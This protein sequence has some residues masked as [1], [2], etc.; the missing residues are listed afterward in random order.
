MHAT[1]TICTWLDRTFAFLCSFK[2]GNAH[3][4]IAISWHR[5]YSNLPNLKP[6]LLIMAC[7]NEFNEVRTST[8]GKCHVL[9]TGLVFPIVGHCCICSCQGEKRAEYFGY[10][11]FILHCHLLKALDLFGKRIELS[12][13]ISHWSVVVATSTRRCQADR[14]CSNIN[15]K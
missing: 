12:V 3:S 8:A 11:Q 7:V 6:E 13:P 4:G 14:L 9:R 1:C 2:L 5:K 10:Y 15:W